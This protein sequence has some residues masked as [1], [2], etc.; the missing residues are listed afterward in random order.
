MTMSTPTG[1]VATIL[2][3]LLFTAAGAT[4]Q[5][6]G[7]CDASA[8]VTL[9]EVMTCASIHIGGS[10]LTS[11]PNADA[12]G[13]GVVRIGEVLRCARSF[14]FG[15][16]GGT[17]TP[18][19]TPSLAP[20]ATPTPTVP[21]PT[22]T[23]VPATSTPTA[24]S[25]VPP[26]ATATATPTSPAGAVCG[27]GLVESGETC[28]SCPADCEIQGCTPAAQTSVFEVFFSASSEVTAVTV[29]LNYRSDVVQLPG[30]R[31]DATV[32]ARITELPTGG[33]SIINDRDYGVRVVK[34]RTEPLPQGRLFVV[35]FD[36]CAGAPAPAF[37]DFACIVDSCA[38]PFSL[39][40]ADCACEVRVP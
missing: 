26:T 15:C 10:D 31:N 36:R 7:D 21:T 33:Q 20:S 12:N 4:A 8:D 2:T 19:P 22:A 37:G 11:C 5:C 35:E 27:N 25:T 28:F 40:V 34:S 6:P 9:G 3:A 24:T 39:P 30:T 17:V 29:D 13:D 23:A 16:S 38:D 32:R 1:F 14:V 18:S